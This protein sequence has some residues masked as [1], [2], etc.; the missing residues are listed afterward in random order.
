VNEF[1]DEM[2]EFNRSVENR[3]VSESES[4]EADQ[5]DTVGTNSFIRLSPSRIDS[6]ELWQGLECSEKMWDKSTDSLFSLGG[7]TVSSESD[8]PGFNSF[9]DIFSNA[10]AEVSRHKR[11]ASEAELTPISTEK[12]RKKSCYLC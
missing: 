6:G 12:R 1:K 11:T 7:Q 8:L 5:I 2:I 3:D 9:D 4:E 10:C